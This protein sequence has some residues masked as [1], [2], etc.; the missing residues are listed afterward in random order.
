MSKEKKKIPTGEYYYSIQNLIMVNYIQKDK[1]KRQIVNQFELKRSQYKY[2]IKD[3]SLPKEKR[4]NAF[5]LLNRLP[6]NSSPV[7]LRNRCII[8][9]RGRGV[10]KFFQLSRIVFR[11]KALKGQLPGVIRSTW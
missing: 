8:S 9:G 3:S 2:I 7:R 4:I 5:F 11:E 6:K 10:L 1:K